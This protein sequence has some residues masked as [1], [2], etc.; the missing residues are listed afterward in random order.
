MRSWTA[1]P[2]APF[3]PTSRSQMASP[4]SARHFPLLLVFAVAASGCLHQEL[5]SAP[6]PPRTFQGIVLL[7]DGPK[8]FS[9]CGYPERWFFTPDSVSVP[10]EPLLASTSEEWIP[11]ASSRDSTYHLTDSLSAPPPPPDTLQSFANVSPFPRDSLLSPLR[12][13]P[14]VDADTTTRLFVHLRGYATEHAGFGPSLRFDRV[15][16]VTDL[17]EVEAA[18]RCSFVQTLFQ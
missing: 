4:F 12:A 15:L 5:D 9:P 13:R 7:G 11:Y 17:L 18:S 16:V 14:S 6:V 10:G 1:F 2:S 8:T 3:R